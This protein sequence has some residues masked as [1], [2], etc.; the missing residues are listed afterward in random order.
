[1]LMYAVAFGTIVGSFPFN[2]LYTQFGARFVFFG[3]GIMS[4]VSTVLVPLAASMGLEYFIAMRILQGI[5]YSAD[6]AAI[7]VLCV[8]WASL[9]QNAFFVSVLTCF[10]PFSTVITNP[11]SGANPVILTVWLC[12]L[13]DIVAAV[14]LMT[15]TP[16]YLNKVLHYDI[17]HSGWLAALPGTC[18]I[19]FKL[20]S[21]YL[22]DK[23]KTFGEVKKMI[24]FNTLALMIPAILYLFLGFVPDELPL[25]AVIIFTGIN[26]FIGANCAGFYKCGMLV[27]RQYS[28]FVVANI[29]FIKCLTLFIAPA[30]IAIFVQDE[31]S[32]FQWRNIFFILSAIQILSHV[33]F[34][35][36]VTNEPAEFTKIT[37][38]NAKEKRMISADKLSTVD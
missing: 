12:A 21:G 29:Q 31:T 23:I 32:R 36:I 13:T 37:R 27:S 15:Y 30:M 34:C 14:F 18:H 16:T 20:V 6:F 4:A 5:A 3:A 35:K 1:M 10:T 19:P 17:A 11:I 7:G 26:T 38:N 2:Y 33:I 25:L 8:R 9:K 22:S 24:F 28:A